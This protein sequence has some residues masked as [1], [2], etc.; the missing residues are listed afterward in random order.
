MKFIYN[1]P[2]FRILLAFIAGII[3]YVFAAQT[4]WVAI[5]L[6]VC[7]LVLLLPSVIVKNPSHQFTLRWTFGLGVIFFFTGIGFVLSKWES[8]QNTFSELNKRAVFLI[9]LTDN[10][11]Q[12]AKSYKCKVQVLTCYTLR[13]PVSVNKNALIYLQKSENAAL[14]KHGNRLLIQTTFKEA[15]GK[16]NPEGFDYKHYLQLLS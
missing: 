7:A 10:P 5:T 2:F 3:L 1:N 14:L 15:P 11:I 16:I 6:I 8:E 13:G 9:E 4:L 12:K